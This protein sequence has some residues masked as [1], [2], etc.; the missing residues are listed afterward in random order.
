[1]A[2]R[3]SWSISPSARTPIRRSMSVTAPA[4]PMC[5]MPRPCKRYAAWTIPAA[6]YS[7]RFSRD[8]GAGART[9]VRR[10]PCGAHLR[11]AGVH[12]GGVPEG[13]ALADTARR[14][15][16]LPASA[17]LDGPARSRA[18]AAGGNDPVSPFVVCTAAAMA[19]PGGYGV[20]GAVR[21]RHGDQYQARAGSHRLRLRRYFPPPDAELGLSHAQH[22][23]VGS[24]AV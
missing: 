21:R 15:R 23:A 19:G 9:A 20:S 7:I 18:V 22:R 24:S 11:R 4:T 10:L 17:P 16:Q 8:G 13:E 14:D 2:S 3:T 12:A 6:A 1:M 5:W